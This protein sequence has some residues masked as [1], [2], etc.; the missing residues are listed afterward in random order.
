MEQ[1]AQYGFAGAS[2]GAV[3]AITLHL[4]NKAVQAKT[5]SGRSEIDP[6]QVIRDNADALREMSGTLRELMTYLRSQAEAEA[7]ENDRNL[8]AQQQLVQSIHG[9]VGMVKELL[10]RVK[11]LKEVNRR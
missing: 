10:E 11:E 7:R 6:Y 2:L 9:I 4:I 3:V 5:S 1:L 8:A